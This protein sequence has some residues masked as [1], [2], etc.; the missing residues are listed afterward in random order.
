MLHG[1]VG[2]CRSIKRGGL[3]V[4][5]RSPTPRAEQGLQ[6]A[7][8]QQQQFYNNVGGGYSIRESWYCA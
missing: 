2:V 5:S 4:R 3:V 7:L 6:W 1:T 8:A